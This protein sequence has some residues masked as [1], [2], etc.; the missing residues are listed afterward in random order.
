METVYVTLHSNYL[1]GTNY[2]IL[3]ECREE[4]PFCFLWEGLQ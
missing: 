4:L 3:R 2:V 1:D